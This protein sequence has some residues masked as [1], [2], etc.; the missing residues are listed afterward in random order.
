MALSRRTVY[1]LLFLTYGYRLWGP[2]PED[3]GSPIQSAA[4]LSIMKIVEDIS[5]ITSKVGISSELNATRVLMSS[6]VKLLNPISAA[7]LQIEDIEIEGVKVRSYIPTDARKFGPGIIYIHGGGWVMCD[8]ETHD[9][10]LRYLAK[11][12]RVSVYAIDYRLAPEHPFPIP[13]DDSLAVTK[14]LLKNARMSLNLNPR[15]IVIMERRSRMALQNHSRGIL[16]SV[17]WSRQKIRAGYC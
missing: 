10:A 16:C 3:L 13:F 6:S 5:W 11:E 15:E 2:L 7:G 4:F 9:P 8:L 12:L 1:G 17:L 14:Y